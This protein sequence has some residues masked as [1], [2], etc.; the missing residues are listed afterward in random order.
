MSACQT[1]VYGHGYSKPA[2][3]A[4]HRLLPL[5]LVSHR[6]SHASLD[7]R[8]LMTWWCSRIPFPEGNTSLSSSGLI[9]KAM[10]WSLAPISF[11][12]TRRPNVAHGF[13]LGGP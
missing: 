2:E 7:Q 13:S 5:R 10:F 8:A 11:A 12:Q 4:E 3:H 9:W 1:D 6:A